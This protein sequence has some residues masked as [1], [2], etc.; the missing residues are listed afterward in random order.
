MQES[1]SLKVLNLSRN[2]LTDQSAKDICQVI[3]H[4][5]TLVSL[6]L[7]YNRIFAKGGMLIAEKLKINSSIQ[8][9]DISF[10][11]IGGGIVTKN[12]ED[13]NKK[14]HEYAQIWGECFS[15]N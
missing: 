3:Y 10:N 4:C 11:S 15:T 13:K 8:I 9:F 6:F 1:T 12:E 2:Q 5:S 7:H 14:M